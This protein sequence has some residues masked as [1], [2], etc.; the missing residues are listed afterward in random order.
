MYTLTD[1]DNSTTCTLRIRA[2][3]A[4]ADDREVVLPLRKTPGRTKSRRC[5]PILMNVN[6][7]S[8]MKPSK[9]L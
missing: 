4:E 2:T 8:E 1:L 5:W 9:M 3:N 7:R 6:R